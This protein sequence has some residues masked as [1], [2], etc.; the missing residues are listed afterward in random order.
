[1]AFKPSQRRQSG[2]AIMDLDIR[3]IMNLM[4][5]LIPLLLAGAQFIKNTQL[6]VNLPASGG[7]S[8]SQDQEPKEEKEE[9]KINLRLSVAITEKGFYVSA[10][11]VSLYDKE[12]PEAPT[13][14]VDEEG[15]HQYLELRARLKELKK[16][17]EVSGKNFAD[18]DKIIIT[19]SKAIPYEIYIK[20]QD[21][22]SAEVV[23]KE[24]KELFPIV[25]LGKVI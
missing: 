24:I 15:N 17:I 8:S 9:K 4:V 13:V 12:Q 1:M 20:T 5:C 22:I 18:K 2:A 3:P 11:N 7:S 6:D 16:E 25:M 23:D 19:A 21:A 14:P 10:S